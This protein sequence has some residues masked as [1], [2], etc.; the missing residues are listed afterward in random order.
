MKNL[1]GLLDATDFTAADGGTQNLHLLDDVTPRN[2]SM[3]GSK[4]DLSSPPYLHFNV[5][6]QLSV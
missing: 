1:V 2:K 5:I 3:W 4:Q 6:F